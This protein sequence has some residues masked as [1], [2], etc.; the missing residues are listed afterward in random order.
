[1]YPAEIVLP[2]K[3]ELIEEGFVEM[4]NATDVETTLKKLEQL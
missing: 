4:L 1:M 2:M 3:A